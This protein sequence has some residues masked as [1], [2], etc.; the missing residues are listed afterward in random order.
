MRVFLVAISLICL[1]VSSAA[2]E[3]IKQVSNSGFGETYFSEQSHPGFED[4]DMAAQELVK[5]EPAAGVENS[6]MKKLEGLAEKAAKALK[7][8]FA[9]TN[10]ELD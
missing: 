3:E 1:N 8:S 2:A 9:E 6:T 10:K 4:P 7:G 5:I